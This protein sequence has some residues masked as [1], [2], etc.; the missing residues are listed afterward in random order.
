MTN[1][2]KYR[3]TRR[4]VMRRGSAALGV[5][6]LPACK[7][8][9][10]S[11]YDADILVLGAGLSGLHAARILDGE[12]RD[13]LV[14][15]GSAR[16]GG[17]LQTL[18]HAGG[19]TTEA[20]GEQVGSSY[21][22]IL[23]TAAALGVSM[24][25]DTPTR[26]GTT[27]H[28]NG[29][30][31][32][33]D[34]WTAS[35]SHPFVGPFKGRTPA[36]PL[37]ALAGQNNPLI[38]AMD[39]RDA[40]FQSFDMSAD[41]FLRGKGLSESARGV[42]GHALNGNRLDSYSMMNLYR[43]LQIYTQSKDMGP[44]LSFDN[45]AEALPEAMAASLSRP[46]QT[47]RRITKIKTT[48]DA[49]IVTTDSGQTVKARH[50]ICTLP[51]GALRHVAIDAPLSA[52]QRS[53]VTRLPYTQILQIHF[54][55]D[56]PYWDGDGLPAD[57]WMDGP[58]ERIFVSRDKDG[59]VFPYGRVWING[60]SAAAI[61]ATSDEDITALLKRELFRTRQVKP[62][63][64]HVLAIKR[65]TSGNV[66]AGGAYMHWAPGQISK[67]ADDM[68]QSAGRLSFAGEHLSNLHTGMEGAMESGENTAHSLLF[69]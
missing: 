4:S 52:L 26:R 27:Y 51:F 1:N 24:T 3:L 63:D 18:R 16:I 44:S 62:S 17:R 20:G 47:G 10:S 60:D 9:L 54:K 61:A 7:P 15:E 5:A 11:G 38:S 39:W 36:A 6:V 35:A 31:F 67:W 56:A 13:V 8:N 12:G 29:Q 33:P 49:V 65:W 19:V 41:A 2:R 46:V 30:L 42:I 53:A 48:P 40:A 57:M 22:R 34:D 32:G 64:T 68:G 59:A 25:A 21:A 45:G 43:S 55:V 66:L 37:F 28:Y 23:D 50:C 14:L 58:L 69:G